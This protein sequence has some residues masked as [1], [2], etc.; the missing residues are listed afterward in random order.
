MKL[1]YFILLLVICGGCQ[2]S[3]NITLNYTA[4]EPHVLIYKTKKDYNNHVPVLLSDDKTEIIS[5]P[6]PDDL[7]V[8]S[9]Y[10]LPTLLNKDYLLDNRG[11]G[12]N[13]A[14]LKFTYEEYSELQNPPTLDE[15]YND[16]IDK[17]PLI[18]FCDCGI[19]SSFTNIE[20]QL[21]GLIN[22]KKLRTTCKVI[23]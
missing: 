19:K 20:K 13:V 3:K 18:E 6:N 21:N 10:L 2:S 8:G 16:I 1:I 23:L 5:Y 22:T 7:K 12:K 17:D 11:I 15:L 4:M 9:N 14:F